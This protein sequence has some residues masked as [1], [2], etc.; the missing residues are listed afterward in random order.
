MV[1]YHVCQVVGGE[2]VR[3]EYDWVPLGGGHVVRAGVGAENK[4]IERLRLILVRH[5]QSYHV[6]L[7]GIGSKFIS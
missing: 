4:V 7:S 6:R 1:V 2:S 5:Q 3:L